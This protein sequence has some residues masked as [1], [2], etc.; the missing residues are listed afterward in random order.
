MQ[1]LKLNLKKRLENAKRI[2][3]LGVGSE[4]RSD[5]AA[6][7]LVAARIKSKIPSGESLPLCVLIGGSAPEN[8]TGQIKKYA[9]THLIIVDAAEIGATPGEWRI[10]EPEEAGGIT[11]STHD[12]SLSMMVDYLRQSIAADVFILGI[13]PKSLEFMGC[14]S[15]EVMESVEEFSRMLGEVIEE[16]QAL[17]NKS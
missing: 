2:M 10:I 12:L 16:T 13:Q 4:L 15:N 14:A 8:V 1:K 9:P 6:G 3:I 7:A 11:F 17:V 5:D